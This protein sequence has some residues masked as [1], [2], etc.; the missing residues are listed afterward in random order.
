MICSQNSQQK[1]IV[2][3]IMINFDFLNKRK[4]TALTV[5]GLQYDGRINIKC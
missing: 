3:Y 4:Q 1:L 2:S 5:N